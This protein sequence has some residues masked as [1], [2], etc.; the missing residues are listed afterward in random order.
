LTLLRLVRGTLTPA[1]RRFTRS[2]RCTMET[3]L[4]VPSAATDWLFQTAYSLG[5]WTYV[6]RNC[7][8]ARSSL[9]LHSGCTDGTGTRPSFE[10]R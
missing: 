4:P 6:P 1:R 10:P 3:R 7:R 8:K 5:R 9:Q 2:E